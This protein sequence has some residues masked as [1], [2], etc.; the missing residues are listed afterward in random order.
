MDHNAERPATVTVSFWLWIVTVVLSAISIITS[1]VNGSYV[2]ADVGG[3]EQVAAAV[4]PAAAIIGLAVGATL[5][6]LFALYMLR[7]RN[8]ARIV[9]LNLAII[10]VLAGLPAFSAGDLVDIFLVAVVLM[11]A[12]LMYLPTSN[13]YFR[14]R[15]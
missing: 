1:L 5:R 11:A 7:G 12:V 8:W 13:P 10:A 9:L 4:G 15:P 2:M 6:V 3:D 14:R